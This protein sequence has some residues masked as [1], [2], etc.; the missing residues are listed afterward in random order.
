MASGNG[1]IGGS[2]QVANAPPTYR[3]ILALDGME[4]AGKSHVALT[5]PGPIAYQD[6]DIG[7][8]GVIEKF[9]SEKVVHRAR[10]QIEVN[11]DEDPA[12]VSKKVTPILTQYLTD[13]REV[14]L[15]ALAKGT[16]RTGVIDTGS[17]LWKMFRLARLGKLTQVLPHH[18]VGVNNEFETLIKAVYHTPGNLIILHKLQAEWKNDALGKANK[19]GLFERAGY[20]GTGFLV[21]VNATVWR[22]RKPTDGPTSGPTGSFHLTVR[23]C[24]QNPAV[25]GLDLTDEER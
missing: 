13:Y 25:A 15:P 16:I 6:L 24:R 7:T 14:M 11:K 9:Q 17:D 3:M 23:D 21:Q 4:K 12:A 10:Y 1:S 2:F 22:E 19:T 5:A 18:Y 8:E 20:A